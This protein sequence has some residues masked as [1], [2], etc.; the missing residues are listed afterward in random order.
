VLAAPPAN[1][2]LPGGLFTPARHWLALQSRASFL[3]VRLSDAN[4]RQ[5]L[6]AVTARTGLQVQ[7]SGTSD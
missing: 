2:D 4:W 3:I 1:V 6:E 5:V 7:L